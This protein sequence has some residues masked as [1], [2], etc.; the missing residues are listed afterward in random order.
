MRPYANLLCSTALALG[1]TTA[2]ASAQNTPCVFTINQGASAFTWSGSAAGFPV[3]GNP[4]NSFNMSGTMDIN[5]ATEPGQFST[6]QLAGGDLLAVPDIH[7][8]VS[9]IFIGQVAT[10][11]ITGLR[12]S[13]RSPA[14]VPSPGPTQWSAPVTMD[15]IA[16]TATIWVDPF[17]G[18]SGVPTVTDLAG[19]SG[20]PQSLSGTIV[21]NG[22]AWELLLPVALTFV[23]E[24][25]GSGLTGTLN[26]NGAIIGTAPLGCRASLFTDT[27]TISIAAG[28][29]HNLILDTGPS[30][31]GDAYWMFG[32]A[33]GTSPGLP[34]PPPLPLNFDD[35]TLF[36]LVNPNS[37]VAN[38][39][40]LLDPL[41][42]GLATL[43]IGAAAL[44][45][46]L[47]GLTL[48]H[49]HV[50]FDFS[51]PKWWK[52]PTETSNATSVVFTP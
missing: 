32:S 18:G 39:L 47:A 23:L 1:L 22:S 2:V 42:K 19:T 31:G 8:Q 24:D 13:P 51:Q 12:L 3:T 36:L 30:N 4:S 5:L 7:G 21:N 40:G 29:T 6:G 28:G 37:V 46:S 41:G 45:P 49:A 43:P 25:P 48:H 16:G 11:D 17:L 50:V 34:G 44:D 27:D 26:L 38:S 33:S 14:F 10:I 20:A 15:V 35:Y 52:F 9:V